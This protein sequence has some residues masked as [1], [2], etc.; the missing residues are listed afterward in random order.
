MTDALSQPK[1]SA[2]SGKGPYLREVQPGQ[3][4]LGYFKVREK[5][6]EKFRDTTRGRY[7]T[8]VLA[9]KSGEM[10]ARV[11]ENAEDLAEKFS[12]GDVVKIIG[13]VELYRNRP[14]LIIQ[15]LREATSNEYTTSDFERTAAR[16]IDEM[17]AELLRLL[18]S[19]TNSSLRELLH[20]L[21]SDPQLLDAFCNAPA[22]RKVHHAYHG[23]LLEHVL[24][25][26]ALAQPLLQLYPELDADLL[27]TGIILH[28]IGKIYEFT[29]EPELDYTDAGRLLGHVV[30][31]LQIVHG[32]IGKIAD[33]PPD[34]SL[35]LQHMLASHHGRY[36]WGS[37]RR[38]KTLEAIALHHLEDLSAQVNRF[39]EVLQARPDRDGHWTT[40]E[41][42]LGRAL[43]LGPDGDDSLSIEESS[44]LL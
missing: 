14:Q 23:G 22:A 2:S 42:S 37:P 28:D 33:F 15:R 41:T 4:I 29:W 7:L 20:L 25:I 8:L 43:Y 26:V 3:R 39:S 30:L 17:R 32:A 40:F 1:E 35:R 38:P 27:L 34:L 5:Q 13:D 19:V 36:E 31:G 10:L 24:E 12:V 18:G 21:F 16:P 6:L 44:Q 9:D 11:W